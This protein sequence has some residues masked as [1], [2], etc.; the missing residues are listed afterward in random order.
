MVPRKVIDVTVGLGDGVTTGG[1]HDAAAIQHIIDWAPPGS[2]IYFPRGTYDIRLNLVYVVDDLG[3]HLFSAIWDGLAAVRIGGAPTSDISGNLVSHPPQ[4]GI[5]L[6][7]EGEQTVLMSGGSEPMLSIERSTDI[8]IRNLSFDARRGKATEAIQHV[9]PM[10]D[11]TPER[12][13]PMV[14]IRSCQRLRV[15]DTRAF[16]SDQPDPGD[17]NY[18]HFPLDRPAFLFRD[19]K[20]VIFRRNCLEDSQLSLAS[21]KRVH[22]LENTFIRP[23]Y[24]AIRVGQAGPFEWGFVPAP[25]PEFEQK[26]PAIDLGAD[27]DYQVVGNCIREPW[28][29]GIAFVHADA[30]RNIADMRRIRIHGNAIT[31]QH[32]EELRL[33]GVVGLPYHVFLFGIRVGEYIPPDYDP[34]LLKEI[35]KSYEDIRIESNAVEMIQTNMEREASRERVSAFIGGLSRGI[36]V[37]CSDLEEE[38]RRVWLRGN[39]VTGPPV[40]LGIWAGADGELVGTI[41]DATIGDNLAMGSFGLAVT[42]AHSCH[43]FQ[44]R[45]AGLTFSSAFRNRF[46]ANLLVLPEVPLA[47]SLAV[48][49]RFASDIFAQNLPEWVQ[50]DLEWWIAR[51]EAAGGE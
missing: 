5:T 18:P 20:D 40:G 23:V 6:C 12:S 39:S 19:C 9:E 30:T 11:T 17:D 43:I 35:A 21:C 51:R 26:A 49:T 32:P 7:G 48:D 46:V 22:I 42:N 13:Y 34:S 16:V 8:T 15:H 3:P 37:M 24:R 29:G 44:N 2:T 38:V 10:P 36:S 41:R 31:R 50:E 25:E 33:V 14:E 47:P 4:W 1:G 28:V 27:E 45:A